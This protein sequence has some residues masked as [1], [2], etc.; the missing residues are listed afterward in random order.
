MEKKNFFNHVGY[1]LNNELLNIYDVS[2]DLCIKILKRQTKNNKS[3][4]VCSVFQVLE[5]NIILDNVV[6]N[7]IYNC[8]NCLNENNYIE[9]VTLEELNKFINVLE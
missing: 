9:N 4:F 7:D 5:N 3:F 2:K 6:F 8:F 1:N